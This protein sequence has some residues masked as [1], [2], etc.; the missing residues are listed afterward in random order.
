MTDTTSSR[1]GVYTGY[2]LSRPSPTPT[3]RPQPFDDCS[4]KAPSIPN[5]RR[6]RRGN[7]RDATLRQAE[8]MS[9]LSLLACCALVVS[10]T[11]QQTALNY[12]SITRISSDSQNDATFVTIPAPSSDTPLYLTLN[13]LSL[14]NYS[15]TPQ[16]YFSNSSS[17]TEP[18]SEDIT[19][20][21]LQD[22][23]SGNADP[24]QGS[25]YAN[26]H[27]RNSPEVWQIK[28][29]QGFGNW[30]GWARDSAWLGID[31][32]N[33]TGQVELG[34]STSGPIHSVAAFEPLLG[35]TIAEESLVLSP[36]LA[37]VNLSQPSYPNYTLASAFDESIPAPSGLPSMR[38]ILVPTSESPATLGLGHSLASALSAENNTGILANATTTN[39]T[40]LRHTEGWRWAYL[41]KGLQPLTNYT[42]WTVEHDD[43]TGTRGTVAGPILLSTKACESTPEAQP[44]RKS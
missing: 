1:F 19:G 25:L 17:V 27:G 20:Q 23:S 3:S 13:I 21:I 12:P 37:R 10:V 15:V 42:A 22:S 7:A 11:A 24:S 28:T 36:I 18:S 2:Y 14:G 6:V 30:T 26:T 33:Q 38:I 8:R 44:H 29:Y 39:T 32:L 43:E 9:P 41:T 40:F 16:F 5:R 4:E 31:W 34:L 35:D